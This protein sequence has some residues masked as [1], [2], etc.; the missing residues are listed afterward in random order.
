MDNTLG[1]GDP[2]PRPQYE[3][4]NLDYEAHMA[5]WCLVL[6]EF[7]WFGIRVQSRLLYH[8]NSS[9]SRTKDGPNDCNH[10]HS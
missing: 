2:L 10:R 5:Y 1:L 8:N 4:T 9:A 7:D 6:R 3:R